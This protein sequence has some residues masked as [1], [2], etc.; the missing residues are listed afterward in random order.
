MNALA[1]E[2]PENKYDYK[3]TPEV[4]T[5]AQQL[6]HV[7]FWNQWAVETARGGKPDP[8]PNELPRSEYKTKAQVVAV[9]KKTF[10]DVIAAIKSA[11]DEENVKRLGLWSAFSEHNGEH[12][13]QL[14]VYY[15]LNGLVPPASR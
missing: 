14:V 9:V 12:Y 1:S 5:F 11:S 6:L 13:G 2:F 3:P 4:R 7:A 8:K 10:D 15:R